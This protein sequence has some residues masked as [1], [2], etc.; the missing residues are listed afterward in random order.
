MVSAGQNNKHGT[1]E[2]LLQ[3]ALDRTTTGRGALAESILRVCL[4]TNSNLSAKEFEITFDILRKL[5]GDVEMEVRRTIAE[6]L[7]TRGD[8]PHDIALFLANDQ[9]EVAYPVLVDS[10]SLE[11]V[12]LI[13]ITRGKPASHQIAVTL[14]RNLSAAV[15][16]ALVESQSP[17]VI[18]SLLRNPTA[19]IAPSTMEMMVELSR[20]M[21]PIQKPLL[22]RTDLPADLAWRMYGWVGSALKNFI[23]DTFPETG[24]DFGSEIDDVIERAMA[25]SLEPSTTEPESI[26][27]QDLLRVLETESLEAFQNVFARFSGLPLNDVPAILSDAGGESMA[28]VCKACGVP[29]QDFLRIFE[30]LSAQLS[31]GAQADTTEFSAVRTFFERLEI[32]SANSILSEWRSA[33][34]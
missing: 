25:T 26:S 23:V 34:R 2:N 17:D 12:D 9:I 5:V 24:T 13:M 1:I 21:T 20:S 28:I 19:E 22:Q 4:Q 30:L 32:K 16:N 27:T 11:D 10:A 15:S 29:I 31:S 14:R 8:L 6:R 33:K 3:M 7:A 18:D